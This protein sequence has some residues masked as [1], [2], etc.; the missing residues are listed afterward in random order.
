M[1]ASAPHDPG[2]DVARIEALLDALARTRRE[3]ASLHAR[4]AEL[5]ASALDIARE[6]DGRAS[7]S[8]MRDIPLRSMA[9]QV[10]LAVRVSDRTIQQ[11]MDAS[12]ILVH[13]FPATH[14]ALAAGD[15]DPSHARV[16]TEAG[17]PIDDPAVRATF[18]L[19]AVD[20]A[21]RETPGRLRGAV[22][23][24]AQRLH[25]VPLADRHRAACAARD[26]TVRDGDDG[27]AE[28]IATLPA[29]IAHG[30]LDRLTRLARATSDDLREDGTADAGATRDECV[31]GEV[32][33]DAL[34]DL[35]LTGHGSPEI[36][37]TSLPVSQAII[38]QVSITVPAMTL[39]SDDDGADPAELVGRGPIDGV[40][41]RQLAG[42]AS[43]WDRVLTHPV[44][45][46]VLAID[47][48]RPSEHL[49]RSLRVRDE[50]CRFPGCRQ[51]TR[52]CDIDHTIARVH[53]G[54]TA[55]DNLA[56]LCRR[57]HVLK[58]HSAW[59]V[60][61]RPDG[62]ME[63]TSPTGRVYPDAP[64]RT[65]TF[66]A[67]GPP[68]GAQSPWPESPWP[69]SGDQRNGPPRAPARAVDPAPF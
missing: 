16:I 27:M 14:A 48:Y 49:R 3:L 41:A 26:V 53:D 11:R 58:H 59:R 32:R 21:R 2:D 15:I 40:T 22:R 54:P 24:L 61:Q 43:G 47:R 52:R 37:A 10:A 39:L 1:T 5:L 46:S 38:A 68:L 51:P 36:T 28:L 12:A 56:H 4:E 63:W 60:R 29:V 20:I 64:A 9:A 17:L 30:I 8:V 44:T 31:L 35:L 57:H 23:V 45:G 33:A 50:H 6:Q 13:R 69:E 18:E 62:V 7:G 67:T 42:A 34:A 19:A 25:P 66:T 55:L 65:L